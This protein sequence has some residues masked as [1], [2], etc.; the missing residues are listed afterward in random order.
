MKT[1]NVIVISRVLGMET[2]F[3]A[4]FLKNEYQLPQVD[5]KPWLKK[6]KGRS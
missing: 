2:Q 6:K 3:L 5:K 4:H 1:S